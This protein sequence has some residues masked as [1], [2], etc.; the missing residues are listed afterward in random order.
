MKLVWSMLAGS[1]L[2]AFILTILPGVEAKLEVWLGMLGPLASALVSWIAMERQYM[3]SPKGLTSLMIKA[4]AAKMVFFAGYVTALLSAGLVRPIPFAVSFV[5]YFL[6][7]HAAEAIGLRRLQ[8][9][10]LFARS[11]ALRDQLRNG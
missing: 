2:S 10:R 8:A 6:C 1:I 11:A 3:R 7:L 9:A 5:G 4:F